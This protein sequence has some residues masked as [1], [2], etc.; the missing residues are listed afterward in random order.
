MK[1]RPKVGAVGE[2]KFVV[3]AKHAI[4]FADGGMPPVLCTPWLIWFLEHAAREAVLPCLE[5]GES[6]V[7][8]EIEVRHVAPTPL[9]HT[10]TCAA[11]VIHVDG[12]RITFQVEAHDQTELIAR[13]VHR[14][15]VIRVA[16]FAKRV[17]QKAVSR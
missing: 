17:E 13:G 12:A 11:R 14:L 6:T 3:E 9:G 4:D 16:G 2:Q 1:S 7:G 10:V 5:A 15:Q 8:L